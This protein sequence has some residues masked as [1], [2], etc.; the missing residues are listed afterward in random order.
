MARK[1]LSDAQ[2]VAIRKD[3]LKR[4]GAGASRTSTSREL[5]RKYGVTTV[6]IR[7]YIKS[8][9]GPASR[10]SPSLPARGSRSSLRLLDIV[11]NVSA[12]GLERALAAKK[13]FLEL[14]AKLE[15]SERLRKTEQEI[16][17]SRETL[18]ASARK[19]EG[20]LHRLTIS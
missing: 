6:T 10:L 4:L 8:L 12:D 19:L 11:K 5:A 18:L 9:K 16:R 3:I 20:K 1:K 2:R 14:Q 17:K 7:W 13:L 15:E